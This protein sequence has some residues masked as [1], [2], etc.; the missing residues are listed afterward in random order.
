[1]LLANQ[2]A[3]LGGSTLPVGLPCQVKTV[4]LMNALQINH[5]VVWRLSSCEKLH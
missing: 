1:M 5:P 3:R 4:A 2:K